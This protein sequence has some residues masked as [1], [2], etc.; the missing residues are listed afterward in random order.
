MLDELSL[1]VL[2]RV[3]GQSEDPTVVDWLLT[4][5]A[6]IFGPT[7][8]PAEHALDPTRFAFRVYALALVR[9][10][11]ERFANGALDAANLRATRQFFLDALGH[12]FRAALTSA[13]GIAGAVA[14][15]D[16]QDVVG[17]RD[18]AAPEPAETL[19]EFLPIFEPSRV[20]ARPGTAPPRGRKRRA[21]RRPPDPPPA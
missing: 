1:R 18:V 16:V 6:G 7:L 15:G 8:H 17:V 10:S 5:W 3:R 19:G 13:G 21:P 20:T 4:H 14:P 11:R 2:A 12:T 9:F